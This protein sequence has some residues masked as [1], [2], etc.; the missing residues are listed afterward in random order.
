LP[1]YFHKSD[2]VI[3]KLNSITQDFGG[4]KAVNNLSLELHEKEILSIIGPNGAG[5]TTLFNLI[6]G[7]YPPT[8]GEIYF[9]GAQITGFK[10]RPL[11]PTQRKNQSGRHHHIHGGAKCKYGPVRCQS[12]VR[13]ADR[14]HRFVRYR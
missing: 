5:K 10:P 7:I 8:A 14:F 11:P 4:I 3:L 12:R 9:E 1:D 13:F 6:S 2:R